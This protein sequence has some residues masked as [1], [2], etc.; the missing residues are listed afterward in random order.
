MPSSEVTRSVLP[1]HVMAHV[2]PNFSLERVR[3]LDF[4]F[5]KHIATSTHPIEFGGFN[6]KLCREQGLSFKPSTKAVYLPLVDMNP[7]HPDSMLSARVEAE[8]FR[9]QC[10]QDIH[11]YYSDK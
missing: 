7:S 2:T 1:L 9:K 3:Q 5:L 10:E 6:T 8:G 11:C 4:E